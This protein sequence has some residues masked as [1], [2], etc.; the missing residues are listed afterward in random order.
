MKGLYPP[1]TIDIHDRTKTS[2]NPISAKIETAATTLPRARETG[3]AT[4]SIQ[5]GTKSFP[6]SGAATISSLDK[7]APHASNRFRAQGNSG[8]LPMI[9]TGSKET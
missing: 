8:T 3:S 7:P 9:N 1:E 2:S 4:R 5:G 6:F